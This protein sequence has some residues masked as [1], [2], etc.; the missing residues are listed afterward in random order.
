MTVGSSIVCISIILSIPVIIISGHNAFGSEYDTTLMTWK[1]V[2]G[3]R[4]ILWL[5]K[6]HHSLMHDPNFSAIL[7]IY[8]AP[9]FLNG[10]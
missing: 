7:K 10:R 9:A 5:L 8:F 6:F 1:G 4:A 3:E 2:E